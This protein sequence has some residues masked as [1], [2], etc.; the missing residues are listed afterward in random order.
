MK[1]NFNPK[2]LILDFDGVFTDNKVYTNSLG[3]E[4]IICSKY[5]SLAISN[6]KDLHPEFK[7]VVISNESNKSIFHRCNKLDIELFQGAKEKLNIAK[8]WAKANHIQLSDC[9]FLCNDSNDI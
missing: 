9:I 3:P 4:Y 1:L 7:M 5:D 2:A 6:F 8:S